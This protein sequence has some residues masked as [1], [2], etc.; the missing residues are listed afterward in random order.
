MNDN[1]TTCAHSKVVLKHTD[2]PGGTRSD[3]WECD[4]GCGTRF[5]P[6]TTY[7]VREVRD[8]FAGMALMG[9]LCANAQT[10]DAVTDK[11]VDAVIAR[12]A[13]MSADAMIQERNK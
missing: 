3:Y 2:C 1:Q 7:A 12:E 13:Y 9:M 11:N 10:H 8:K 4:S 6:E 5:Y